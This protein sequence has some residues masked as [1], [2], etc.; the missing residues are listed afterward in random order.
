MTYLKMRFAQFMLWVV[1]KYFEEKIVERR[2]RVN[3]AYAPVEEGKVVGHVWDRV[4]S[5]ESV[6]VKLKIAFEDRF[7][8]VHI[9]KL[10]HD[11]AQRKWYFQEG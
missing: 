1:C 6:A 7:Q 3:H 2:V 9:S 11:Y 4:G 10:M 5:G 8:L